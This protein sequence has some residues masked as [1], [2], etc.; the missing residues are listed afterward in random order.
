MPM[1]VRAWYRLRPIDRYATDRTPS[2]EIFM[3]NARTE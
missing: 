3:L 1:W 2:A